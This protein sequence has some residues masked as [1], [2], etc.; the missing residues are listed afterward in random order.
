MHAASRSAS[1]K[2]A[3]ALRRGLG[4]PTHQALVVVKQLPQIGLGPGVGGVEVKA[5]VPHIRLDI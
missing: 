5:P 1:E 4:A 3:T 2:L